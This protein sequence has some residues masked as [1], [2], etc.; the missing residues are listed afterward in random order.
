MIVVPS[1]RQAVARVRLVDHG[2]RR[3]GR[4]RHPQRQVQRMQ[5]AAAV[6]DQAAVIDVR[7]QLVRQSV[8][9]DQ[10]HLVVAVAAPHEL[11]MGRVLGLAALAVAGVDH[12]GAE[13]AG[14]VV[15]G[16][17]GEQM[18]AGLLAHRPQ[19]QGVVAAEGLL[20]PGLVVALADMDLSAVSAA[21][22]GPD[23]GGFERRRPRRRASPARAPRQGRCSQRRRRR[24]RRGCRCRA[25]A[26][27]GTASPSGHTRTWRGGRCSS[28]PLP[29]GGEGPREAWEGEEW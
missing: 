17:Q 13:V 27:S 28:P 6:V 8:R 29:W 3:H 12:A 24:R 20:Q 19:R 21:A 1:R 22:T 26:A 9:V 18:G 4:P 11:D 2:P 15:L 5:V 25:A 14:D 16:D 23:L 7:A 10:R